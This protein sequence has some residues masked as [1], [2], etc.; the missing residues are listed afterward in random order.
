MDEAVA[1][2][3]SRN[4]G[5]VIG[6]VGLAL[7]DGIVDGNRGRLDA[8]VLQ[9]NDALDGDEVEPPLGEGAAILD[10]QI[11]KHPLDGT[12]LDSV[13][14][15]ADVVGAAVATLELADELLEGAC[16]EARGE[17]AVI[18]EGAPPCCMWPRA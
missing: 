11:V 17:Q 4:H 3:R 16:H 5:L 18:C 10:V 2:E 1:R 15:L 8:R 12:R 6:A 9:G 13:T 7:L 14:D